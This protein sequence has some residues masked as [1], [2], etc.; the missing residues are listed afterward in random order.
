MT[1]LFFADY[2]NV[3]YIHGDDYLRAYERSK[4]MLVLIIF[5]LFEEHGRE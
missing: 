4:G 1:V 5:I 2:K 3:I